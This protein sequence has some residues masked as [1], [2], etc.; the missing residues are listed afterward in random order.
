MVRI[1][2]RIQYGDYVSLNGDVVSYVNISSVQV[3]DSGLYECRAS[4]KQGTVGHREY[5]H[6]SGPLS[7]SRKNFRNQTALAGATVVLVCPVLGYPFDF[8][9][10]SKLLKNDNAVITTS[11]SISNLLDEVSMPNFNEEKTRLVPVKSSER[12]R[13]FDNGTLIINQVNREIDSGY[14]RCDTGDSNN[15]VSE[16]MYLDIISKPTVSQF[17]FPPHLSQGMR[18]IITC[19]VLTGDPPIKIDW[20][21]T[22]HNSNDP[23]L[24]VFNNINGKLLSNNNLERSDISEVGSSLVFR[25]VDTTH[26]GS[27]TCRVSNLGIINNR[28]Y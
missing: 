18:I 25:Q 1:V 23:Q 22:P 24:I 28:F 13:V 20:L 6:V 27:Y 14:Y 2:F 12:Y 11:D 10:F 8:I 17:A 3:A 19:N 26:R 21:H 7:I 15:L 16:K 9:R 4:N 5:I